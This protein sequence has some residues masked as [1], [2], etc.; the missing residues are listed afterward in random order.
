MVKV[1]AARA[2]TVVVNVIGVS[3]ATVAVTVDAPAVA[4]DVNVVDALPDASVVAVEEPSVPPPL[5]TAKVTVTPVI[6]MP[7]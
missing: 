7:V 2:A 1:V 3:P 5:A 6:A 4:P